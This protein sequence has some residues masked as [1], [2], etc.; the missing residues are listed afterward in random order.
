M[1][2]SKKVIEEQPVIEVQPETKPAVENPAFKAG[3]AVSS[4][5]LL[6]HFAEQ[7]QKTK[8]VQKASQPKIKAKQVQA[9]ADD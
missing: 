2:R 5:E 8:A 4:A 7:R 9:L 3:Q 6:K 1:A